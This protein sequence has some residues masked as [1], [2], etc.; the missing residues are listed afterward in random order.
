MAAAAIGSFANRIIN[1]S[2]T[3]LGIE[4]SSP[5]ISTAVAPAVE[6]VIDDN[7]NGRWIWVE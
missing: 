3:R 7:L 2:G 4:G 5:A 1:I 6:R